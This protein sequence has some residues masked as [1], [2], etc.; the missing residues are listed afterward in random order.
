MKKKKK[1][2]FET[3]KGLAMTDEYFHLAF[4]SVNDEVA[5]ILSEA[6]ASA[7]ELYSSVRSPPYPVSRKLFRAETPERSA[8]LRSVST[9][10]VE[11]MKKSGKF[12]S[13]FGTFKSP[14]CI[15]DAF[16]VAYPL[17]HHVAGPTLHRDFLEK[18]VFSVF[19][20]LTPV[21]RDNGTVRVYLK[22]TKWEKD[23]K[24][25]TEQVV[26]RN[27]RKFGT[28]E[29]LLMLGEECDVIAFDSRLLHRSM[30]NMTDS[31]RIVF[32]VSLYDSKRNSYPSLVVS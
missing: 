1:I 3:G 22:S 13:L 26:R 9:K 16:V 12:E 15:D 21:T 5:K 14:D 25:S 10:I 29:S 23:H 24:K 8:A 19:F 4:S 7:L 30:P 17:P 20:L 2:N 18:H 6:K 11:A 27:E 28:S 31:E 32:A